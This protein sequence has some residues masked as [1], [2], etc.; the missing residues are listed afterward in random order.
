MEL[1]TLL[2][3]TELALNCVAALTTAPVKAWKVAD[4]C[5]WSLRA[6][7]GEMSPPAVRRQVRERTEQALDLAVQ[8]PVLAN[9]PRP[10]WKP[11]PGP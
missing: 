11:S 1:V 2:A 7:V 5:W 9:G 10:R 4:R 6:V 3:K 8:L